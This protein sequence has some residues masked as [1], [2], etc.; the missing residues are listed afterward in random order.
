M[1]AEGWK[2]REI[3]GE[4]RARLQSTKSLLQALHGAH[5]EL[6]HCET[7]LRY[8]R[9][10]ESVAMQAVDQ[11]EESRA[12]LGA[13]GLKEGARIELKRRLKFAGSRCEAM[14]DRVDELKERLR[15]QINVVRMPL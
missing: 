1:T 13:K 9:R 7:V 10:Y 2:L 15:G 12:R 3:S 14:G 5:T 11:A 6:S 8:A 4:C